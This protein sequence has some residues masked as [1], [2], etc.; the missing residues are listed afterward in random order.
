MAKLLIKGSFLS[1]VPHQEYLDIANSGVVCREH[2][3][4]EQKE[5]AKPRAV[6]VS[7]EAEQVAELAQRQ[8]LQQRERE[9]S[10][11]VECHISFVLAMN[12]NHAIRRK[13]IVSANAY[14]RYMDLVNFLVKLIS[15]HFELTGIGIMGPLGYA[16]VNGQMEWETMIEV[17]RSSP[18]LSSIA[19]CAV[20]A[21]PKEVRGRRHTQP[22]PPQTNQNRQ[23]E[24][25]EL[26]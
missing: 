14:P 19:L 20:E 16:R 24:V 26:D 15:D 2:R 22:R 13:I 7:K 17:I 8:V 5:Q 4:R 6:S 25:I 11:D 1:S 3:D 12:P 10:N 23:H 9:P 18:T 21:Q